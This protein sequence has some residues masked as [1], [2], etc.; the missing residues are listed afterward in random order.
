MNRAAALLL[1]ATLGLPAASLA[2]GA[3]PPVAQKFYKLFD[4]LRAAQDAKAKGVN[5]PINFT[6]TEREIND[7]MVYSLKATPRPG[8]QSVTI[9]FFPNNYVSTYT[10]IDFDAVEKWKPGTI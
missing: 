1:A 3:V 5:K 10:V 4:D 7:Y 2:A 8:L 9:K 6:L